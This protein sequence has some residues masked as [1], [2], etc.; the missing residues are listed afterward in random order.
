[1]AGIILQVEE[2]NAA[3]RALYAS[4]GYQQVHARTDASVLRLCPGE[5]TVA[6]ALMLASNPALLREVPSTVVTMAKE[7]GKP[8]PAKAR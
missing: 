6:S 7:I 4:L 8:E 1:V 5:R 2:A 3:A